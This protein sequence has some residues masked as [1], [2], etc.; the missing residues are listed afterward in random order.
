MQDYQISY[1]KTKKKNPFT[2][3]EDDKI[4]ELVNIYGDKRWSMISKIIGNRNPKQIRQRWINHLNPSI[5]KRSF[6][7]EEDLLILQKYREYG[8]RWTLI[9]K[10]FDGRSENAIKNRFY[11]KHMKK[12]VYHKIKMPYFTNENSSEEERIN[13]P[14]L[15]EAFPFDVSIPDIYPFNL[16]L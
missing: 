14:S 16:H 3:E 9:S 10:F 8:P 13:L 5:R 15:I 6:T 2:K 7:F 12:Y 1:E 11:E 4:K